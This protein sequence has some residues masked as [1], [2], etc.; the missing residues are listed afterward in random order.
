MDITG[1][2]KKHRSVFVWLVFLFLSFLIYGTILNDFFL[3]DDWH[4]L[5]LA[6][7]R[8]V[9]WQVFLTNYAGQ[10]AGGSYNPLLFLFYKFFYSIFGIKYFWYHFVSILVHSINAFLVYILAKQIFEVGKLKCNQNWAVLVGLLFVF[11]P[12]QVEIITWMAAWAHL[13]PLTF[14]ILSLIFYFAYKKSSQARYIFLTLLFFAIALLTKEI[15]ISLPFIILF[16]EIY[17]YSIGQKDKK[18]LVYLPAYFFLLVIFFVLRYISTA[19]VFGYYG[20]QEFQLDFSPWIANI[21]VFVSDILSFA[22]LRTEA[23]KAAYYLT[24]AVAISVLVVLAV[25]FYYLLVKKKW[26]AFTLFITFIISLG[27][28][29][30]VGLHRTSFAGERYLYLPLVFFLLWLVWLFSKW[31]IN[32][33]LKVLILILFALLSMIVIEYKKNLWQEASDLSRQI[34]SSYGKLDLPPGQKLATIALPDNLS[35]AEVYRNNLNQ[36]LYFMYPDTHPDIVSF[37]PVYVV[38]NS[39]NKNDQL[40]KWQPYRVGWLAEST[41]GGHIVTGFTSVEYLGFYFELWNYNYQ[42]YKSNTIRLIPN[43]EMLERLESGEV[44]IMIFDGGILKILE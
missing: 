25:Y 19:V 30:L 41:D 7:Q 11:W 17:F 5:Y 15:A 39:E 23:Y 9:D 43:D 20:R 6:E 22:F 4:W 8:V 29:I 34:I 44:K 27:P 37:L 13:F 33:K 3:S 21:A 28:A 42:N 40:L 24:D 26:L 14:Y 35:G 38:V 2:I 12:V 16:W 1:K 31:K 10:K 36:A 32:Y 18:T